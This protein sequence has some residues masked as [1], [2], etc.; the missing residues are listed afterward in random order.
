MSE[1][2]GQAHDEQQPAITQTLK[3][4]SQ[5][6]EQ[7]AI[8]QVL[9]EIGVDLTGFSASMSALLWVLYIALILIEASSLIPWEIGP[10]L[11][12]VFY[13]GLWFFFDCASLGSLCGE[14]AIAQ[15]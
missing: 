12:I 1:E 3:Q 6:T 8:T 13:F 15:K 14:I 10:I 7:P 9:K 4:I 5:D 11:S 2:T